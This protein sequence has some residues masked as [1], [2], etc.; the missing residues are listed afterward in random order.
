M[1]AVWLSIAVVAFLATGCKHNTTT[2]P[3]TTTT[4]TTTS[5]TAPITTE[6][7]DGTLGVGA[8]AFYPFTV[9]QAGSVTATLVSIS[10]AMVPATV[11]VRLGIGTPD[12]AGGC[13]TTTMSLVNSALPTLS[14]TESPGNFCANITDVGNLAGTATFVVTIAHP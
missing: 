4:A 8:T 10:G 12:D 3:T 14:A 5:S 7:F 11:Q 2:S 13:T 1:R 9:S 6:E